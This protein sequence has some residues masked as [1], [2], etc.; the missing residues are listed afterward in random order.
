MAQKLTPALLALLTT[1][2]LAMGHTAIEKLSEIAERMARVEERL[3]HEMAQS[4][5]HRAKP[6]HSE[7]GRAIAEISAKLSKHND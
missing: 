7:A 6:W 5:G 1:A 3:G 4:A 2:F